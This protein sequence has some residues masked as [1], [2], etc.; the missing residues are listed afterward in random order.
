MYKRF[1][2]WAMDHLE[3][4]PKLFD[5]FSS[6]RNSTG[7]ERAEMFGHLMAFLWTILD[8]FPEVIAFDE[9]QEKEATAVIS[10]FGFDQE[11]LSALFDLITTILPIFL[12]L[13]R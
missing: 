5:L 13:L 4:L 8:D 7:A 1:L 6:F 11:S 3:D 2:A 10:E 12:R 9:Q